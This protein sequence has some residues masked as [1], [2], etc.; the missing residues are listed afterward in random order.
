MTIILSVALGIFVLLF[1]GLA[2]LVLIFAVFKLIRWL[3]RPKTLKA[4]VTPEPLATVNNG[5]P[6][7]LIR[8][9]DAPPPRT[10]INSQTVQTMVDR[11]NRSAREEEE[12]AEMDGLRNLLNKMAD[13]A[14]AGGSASAPTSEATLSI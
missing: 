7:A 4:S 8:D 5:A 2:G 14:P 1:L 10:R 13:E 3:T 12:R 11:V 6:I 9:V